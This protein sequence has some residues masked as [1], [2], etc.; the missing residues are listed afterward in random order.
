MNNLTTSCRPLRRDGNDFGSKSPAAYADAEPFSFFQN[1]VAPG[2]R[3]NEGGLAYAG[4][5]ET[6]L[7]L[8]VWLEDRSIF[9]TATENNQ[10]LFTLGDVAEFFIKPGESREDYWEIHVSPNDL[11]MDVHF[12]SRGAIR[13]GQVTWEQVVAAES[14]SRKRVATPPEEGYWVTELCVPWQAFGYDCPP[15]PDEIWQFSVSR[16]NYTGDLDHVEHSSVAPFTELNFHQY[17]Q[18]IN[19]TFG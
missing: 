14:G 1:W 7:C 18:F 10:T 11:L 17:E 4:T 2:H 15:E 16:Y 5:T 6:A 19:L 3:P 8:Y 9:T 12:P 13:S